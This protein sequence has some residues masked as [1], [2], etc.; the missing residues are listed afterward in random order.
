[1]VDYTVHYKVAYQ[2]MYMYN[3]KYVMEKVATFFLLEVIN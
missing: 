3:W 1:V 2:Y